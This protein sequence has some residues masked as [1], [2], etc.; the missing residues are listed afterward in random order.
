MS[1]DVIEQ[2]E[3]RSVWKGKLFEMMEQE[4]KA[5]GT[6]YQAL[7]NFGICF[8]ELGGLK[9]TSFAHARAV[10]A[11]SIHPVYAHRLR[12]EGTWGGLHLPLQP[13]KNLRELAIIGQKISPKSCKFS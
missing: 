12:R 5:K 7:P 13:W 2:S 3:I 4:F 1:N 9:V 11:L 6:K 10:S 8:R